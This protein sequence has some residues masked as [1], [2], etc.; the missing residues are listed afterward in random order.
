MKTGMVWA[1]G[2]LRGMEGVLYTNIRSFELHSIER[3]SKMQIK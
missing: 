1:E 3:N 2:Q